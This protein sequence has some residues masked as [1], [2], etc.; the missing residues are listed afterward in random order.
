M[1]LVKEFLTE[2]DAMAYCD[3]HPSRNLFVE[4]ALGGVFEVW[5][6]DAKGDG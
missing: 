1:K 4:P 5:D 3:E 2:A 6:M